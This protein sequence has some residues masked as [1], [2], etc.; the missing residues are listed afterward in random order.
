MYLCKVCKFC[1]HSPD[2]RRKRQTKLCRSCEW[3]TRHKLVSELEFRRPTK[4]GDLE[5]SSGVLERGR[6]RVNERQRESGQKAA[7]NFVDS[8]KHIQDPKLEPSVAGGRTILRKTKLNS[9]SSNKVL[10]AYCV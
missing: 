10:S 1:A 5:L 2:I 8:L 7:D 6:G 9:L 3:T 4:R